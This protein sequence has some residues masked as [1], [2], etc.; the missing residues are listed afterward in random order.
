MRL[1]LR[2]ILPL[3]LTLSFVAYFT[4]P[5]IDKLTLKWFSRDL[6]IRSSLVAN[7]LSEA[8]L[9]TEIQNSAQQKL[10]L[11]DLFSR[12]TQ[13][14][15]LFAIAYCG[16]NNSE[17]I[18]SPQMPTTIRCV[19]LVQTSELRPKIL[20]FASG[21]LHV[22][23]ALIGSQGSY[24]ILVHDMSFVQRRTADT[25]NYVFL[26]FI[27]L[28]L[29]ISV[30]T[31]LIAQLSWLGWIKGIRSML[32]IHRPDIR[33]V[34]PELRPIVREIRTLFRD[35]EHFSRDEAQI[36]W[37]AQTLRDVL[38]NDLAGEEVIIVSNREPYIHM[39]HDNKIEIQS[40]ASGLVTA[41]EPVMRACSGTW[42]AHGSGTADADVVDSSQIVQVPPENP[43][44][45]LKR[46]WLTKEEELGYYYGFSNEGLWPLCHI[47]H[48]RPIFRSDDW[49]CY[50]AVNEKFAN[51]VI[52]ECKT[53]DPVILVQDYHLAMVPRLIKEKLP[54]ATVI[55]FW[56]IPWPNPEAF[57]ICP[58]RERILDGLLGS[59]ILGF[60]TR[61]H[62]NNFTDTVDRFLESRIDRDTSTISYNGSKTAVRNYPISI[63]WPLK[64]LNKQPTIPLCRLQVCQDNQ[65]PFDAK[66]GIGVDRL[67]YT[68]GIL[69]RFYAVERLLEIDSTLLGKLCFVQIGAPSRSS[70]AEYQNFENI[71]RKEAARINQKF[72]SKT[73]KP[74]T[75]RVRHHQPF[76]VTTYFRAADFCFVSS[77][78]DGMNLV[79]K[80]FIAARDDNNGVLILS[81]FAGAAKEL[82]ESIVVN[83]YNIDQCAEAIRLALVMPVPEQV[84]RMKSMRFYIQEYNVFRWAGRM[85]LDAARM[86]KRG[87]FSNPLFP[88]L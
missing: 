5:L 55:T 64:D 63:E 83:P 80:E 4:V 69:E 46:V 77:L 18:A 23:Y 88:S 29:V 60:H 71:V 13:D 58:W 84:A 28:A 33:N 73:Y 22:S 27:L 87:K 8:V 14:E 43:S 17:M 10:R 74:I 62:C 42:V 34:A 21:P 6:E 72:G 1:S 54:N 78:H 81:Q 24:L 82:V 79:A 7:T 85:L 11:K 56:H 32:T 67:D 35:R 44:Y 16:A 59:D 36:S 65:L 38:K 15:R 40:P 31:V 12:A 53:E 68:K 30:L 19:T 75:L 39:H 86:R 2:F 20:E 57:G 70:I 25:K 26:F 51:A 66:I 3:I 41:L 50:L 45:N 76:E 61:F 49:K 37:S 52:E 47:A 9:S 48:T